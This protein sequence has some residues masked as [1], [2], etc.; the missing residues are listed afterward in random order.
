M[1]TRLSRRLRIVGTAESRKGA[2][3]VE[4]AFVVPVFVVFLFGM[5]EVNHAFMVKALL[6][7]AA[8]QAARAGVADGVTSAEVIERA[9]QIVGSG[10]RSTAVSIS[11]KSG[12]VFDNPGMSPDEVDYSLLPDIEIA[13]CEPRELYIVRIEVSYP[14]VSLLP[15]RFLQGAN[16]APLLLVGQ[17]TVRH[18]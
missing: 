4:M 8:E 6:R 17:S 14:E 5:F 7:S 2:T 3:I 10:M 13:E 9:R 16:G 12:S 11:V 1:V 15:P 18:E